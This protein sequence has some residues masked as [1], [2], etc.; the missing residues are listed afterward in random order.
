[1]K[2]FIYSRRE[3]FLIECDNEDLSILNEVPEKWWKAGF[4][5]EN[6]SLSE[7]FTNFL[8]KLEYREALHSALLFPKKQI[9]IDLSRLF[10]PFS[11]FISTLIDYSMKNQVI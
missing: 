11:Y 2:K 5:I 8:Y 3:E 10:D 1:M 9:T 7:F 4:L 6:Y